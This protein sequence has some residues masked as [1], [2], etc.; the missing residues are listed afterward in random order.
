LIAATETRS[1]RS[2]EGAATSGTL[3]V[4]LVGVIAL[5]FVGT[6]PL[7]RGTDQAGRGRTVAEAAALAGA[8]QVREHFLTELAGVSLG[9]LTGGGGLQGS[10]SADSPLPMMGYGEA[11]AY[12]AANDGVV[13][14]EWYAYRVSDGTVSVRARLREDAPGGGHTESTATA[15]LG[16]VLG[17][18]R[19][20]AS[21]GEIPPP[22]PPPEPTPTPTDE[23][24]PSPTPTEPP[25]PQYTPW[26]F[27]FRCDGTGTIHGQD[28]A[29]VLDR[30]H[31][32]LASAAR[33]RLVE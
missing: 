1:I 16:V 12:A 11:A 19:L 23:P 2:D 18:C 6:V 21:R 28:L 29:S 8:R 27:T 33:P 30:A 26:E 3:A 25:P 32:M 24:T 17:S 22:P 15:R 5:L 14:P 7:L 4:A 13:P 10:W 31:D 20:R 9:A